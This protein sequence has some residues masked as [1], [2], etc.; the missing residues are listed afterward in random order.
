MV[1][2]F[3]A[4]F[5]VNDNQEDTFNRKQNVQYPYDQIIIH[6]FFVTE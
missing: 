1:F 4:S 2:L 6:M 3:R 5:I